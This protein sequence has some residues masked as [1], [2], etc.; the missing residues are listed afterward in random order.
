MNQTWDMVGNRWAVTLLQRHIASGNLRHAYL[1]SG[2]PG[3]GRRTLALRFAQAALCQNPPEPGIPC[4]SCRECRQIAA[5][6][7]PDLT[8]VQAETVGGTLKVEQVREVRRLLNLKPYQSDRRVVLFLRFDEANPNAANALLKTLEEPP[9]YALLLLTASAP[10]ALLPTIVSRCEVIRLNPVSSEEIRAALLQHNAT[11]QQ[12]EELSSLAEGRPGRAFH[13]LAHPEELD[14]YHEQIDL[15]QRL[16]TARRHE[17]FNTAEKLGKD[18]QKLRQ[19]LLIWLAFWRD[20]MR[21][22]GNPALPIIHR[23]Y[24]KLVQKLAS[25][26][27]FGRAAKLVQ[28]HDQA[29]QDLDQHANSLLLLETLLLNWPFFET[30]SLLQR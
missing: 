11:P 17:R 7:H 25:E 1:F 14:F 27:P 16:L 4:G 18:R 6:Q 28:R 10:E 30:E 12:A 22:S 26:I 9:D 5:M 13:L 29:L 20:V 21:Q 2:A 24:S 19:A 23:R 3:I 8:V 15:L